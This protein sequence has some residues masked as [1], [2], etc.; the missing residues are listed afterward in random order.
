MKAPHAP[1]PPG[2]DEGSIPQ[3]PATPDPTDSLDPLH[4]DR[5]RNAQIRRQAAIYTK[6]IAES[7]ILYDPLANHYLRLNESAHSLW[8]TVGDHE[9]IAVSEVIDQVG[10]DFD[11][12]IAAL[13]ALAERNFIVIVTH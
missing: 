1:Q 11:E 3:A 9:R 2:S 13:A 5:F 6:K 4:P 7:Y 8:T 12:G 10:C